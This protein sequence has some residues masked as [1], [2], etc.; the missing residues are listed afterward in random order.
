MAERPIECSQC[1]RSIAIKYT[2]VTGEST[3]QTE[4]CNQCP[5]FQMKIHGQTSAEVPQG[6]A[7]SDAGICCGRCGTTML[8]VRTGSPLGCSECYEVFEDMLSNEIVIQGYIP[9]RLRK[10][11][12]GNKKQPLHAGKTPEQ[13]A[14]IA[15]LNRIVNLNEALKEALKGENYEQAAWLRDQ[16]KALT[17]K[18]RHDEGK[19]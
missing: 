18:S 14:E 11:I 12:E 16:I 13:V 19:S 7:G 6:F 15:S 4:M 3:T 17:E 2:E 10:V 8:A 5:I 1:T 9:I